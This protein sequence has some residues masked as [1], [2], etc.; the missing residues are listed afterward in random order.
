MVEMIVN[1]VLVS[2]SVIRVSRKVIGV[3][4]ELVSDG[5]RGLVF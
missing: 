5:V 1:A 4:V 2:D 3:S